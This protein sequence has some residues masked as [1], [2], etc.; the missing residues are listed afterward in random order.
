MQAVR[1]IHFDPFSGASGD[2]VLGALADVG[3][4]LADVA[5]KLASFLPFG[6]SLTAEPFENRGIK[7]THAIVVAE[8]DHPPHRG[9]GALLEILAGGDLPE[10][11]ALASEE[12]FRLIARAEADVHG[13]TPEKIHFH[14]I[15]AGDTLIDVIGTHLAVHQLG[16]ESVTSGPVAVGSGTVECAHGVLPVPAPATAEILTGVPIRDSQALAELTTPTG[17]ALLVTLCDSYAATPAFPYERV[18]YGFGTRDPG[19]LPNALRVFLGERD[20][21]AG[22]DEVAVLETTIDD[23]SGELAGNLME[24]LFAAG[25]LDVATSPVSMKKNRPAVRITVI[26]RPED[27]QALAEAILRQS[28]TFGVRVRREARVVLERRTETVQTPW[29]EVRVKIGALGGED[30]Q[31]SPEFEDCK[32]VADTAGVP[33]KDVMRT[34]AGLGMSPKA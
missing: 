32:R 13:T 21:T 22:R 3:A 5:E 12:T 20:A 2:M 16:V 31:V 23:M 7:G 17:A 8:E 30:V 14:E 24:T 11:V 15:G 19:P 1:A 4:D 9:L 27:E 26:A 6:I 34:A 10:D 28:T 25:A 18:G 33:L 29:G